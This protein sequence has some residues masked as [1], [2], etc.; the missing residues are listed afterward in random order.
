MVNPPLLVVLT[1]A[2]AALADEQFERE[3]AH[4]ISPLDSE[5]TDEEVFEKLEELEGAEWR[6][7]P[8]EDSWTF[9]NSWRCSC[10]QEDWPPP[11]VTALMPE[12][13][14]VGMRGY[15]WVFDE[16][17]VWAFKL[18]QCAACAKL[19]YTAPERVGTL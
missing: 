12:V 3:W 15:R 13:R 9:R 1:A 11:R 2:G 6:R 7:L 14:S 5:P 16:E 17:E 18:G 8:S 10:T 4:G 19:Y